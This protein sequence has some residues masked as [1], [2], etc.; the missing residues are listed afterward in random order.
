[1]KRA[2]CIYFHINNFEYLLDIDKIDEAPLRTLQ[3]FAECISTNR[4][5]NMEPLMA[6]LDS[7]SASKIRHGI[8]NNK[9]DQD[10]WES[11]VLYMILPRIEKLCR[12]IYRVATIISY[13]FFKHYEIAHDTDLSLIQLPGVCQ[14][15]QELGLRLLETLPTSCN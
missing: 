10:Y 3:K 13:N 11:L 14:Q 12:Q 1:M 5:P 6:I 2:K 8:P 9:R 15:D 4:L 7:L